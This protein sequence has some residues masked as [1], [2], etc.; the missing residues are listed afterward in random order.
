M[1][2]YKIV[3]IYMVDAQNRISARQ[4]FTAA[5]AINKEE[6]YLEHISI[7]DAEPLTNGWA[8]SFKKQLTGNK[9]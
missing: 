9:H 6:E 2:K 8:D 3:K 5:Q 7:K 1:R 4:K